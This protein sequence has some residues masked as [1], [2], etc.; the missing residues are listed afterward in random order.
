[1]TPLMKRIVSRRRVSPGT[2]LPVTLRTVDPRSALEPSLVEGLAETAALVSAA[3]VCQ[4]TFFG[5][6]GVAGYGAG[7]VGG[8]R[9]RRHPQHGDP[10]KKQRGCARQRAKTRP[11]AVFEH[12]RGRGLNGLTAAVVNR[13]SWRHNPQHAAPP[14]TSSSAR[15]SPLRWRPLTTRLAAARASPL[16]LRADGGHELITSSPSR[17]SEERRRTPCA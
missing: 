2:A 12:V 4:E 9:S 13:G 7:D 8:L 3:A 11:T 15:R 5:R 17:R 16:T 1:M 14:Q 6:P 10:S